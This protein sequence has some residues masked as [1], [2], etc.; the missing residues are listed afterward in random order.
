MAGTKGQTSLTTQI[1]GFMSLASA[2]EWAEV[3][4]RT[5]Q[6]WIWRGLPVYQSGPRAK[7]LIRPQDIETFLTRRQA[8]KPVLDVLIEE[9]WQDLQRGSYEHRH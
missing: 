6:R 3:S 8:P 4:P 5:L 2:A 1:P 7:V 9:T